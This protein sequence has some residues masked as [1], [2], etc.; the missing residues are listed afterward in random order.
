MAWET[1]QYN[2]IV[3]LGFAF[4]TWLAWAIL[5]KTNMDADHQT[6]LPKESLSLTKKYCNLAVIKCKEKRMTRYEAAGIKLPSWIANLKAFGEVG[7]VKTKW[8]T[9]RQRNHFHLFKLPR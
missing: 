8:E 3:E 4:C 5:N 6:Q 9:W 2:S 7:V 1:Q